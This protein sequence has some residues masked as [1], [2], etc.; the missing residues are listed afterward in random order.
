[1][2]TKQIRVPAMI[3]HLSNGLLELMSLSEL[4]AMMLTMLT[5]QTRRQWQAMSRDTDE[6]QFL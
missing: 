4:D 1:M 2:E 6:H 3:N 5:P